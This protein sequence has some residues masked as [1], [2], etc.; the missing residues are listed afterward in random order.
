[1]GLLRMSMCSSIKVAFRLARR[2]AVVAPLLVSGSIA[3]AQDSTTTPTATPPPIEFIHQPA[4]A[5]QLPPPGQPLSLTVQL[6]NSRD[7]ERRLRMLAAVDGE[8]VDVFVDG[9]TLNEFDQP[10]YKIETFSPLAQ[11]SYQ[12]VMRTDDG[13][14][15][16]S[17]RFVIRRPCIPNVSL[18]DLKAPADG[19]GDARLALAV[20]RAQ[21][22]EGE[23]ASYETLLSLVNQIK[24]RLNQ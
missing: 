7:P 8:F 15:V 13:G 14:V 6:K 2:C 1:M 3:L 22:L 5:A 4:Q 9:G 18:V 19:S 24:E 16:S 11:I 10:V 17:P 23:I 20:E 21:R 12:F